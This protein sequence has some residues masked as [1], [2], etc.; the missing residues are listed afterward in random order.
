LRLA[1]LHI[2]LHRSDVMQVQQVNSDNRNP[3]PPRPLAQKR[4]AGS[5]EGR[6]LF[7]S[8]RCSLFSFSWLSPVPLQAGQGP[9]GLVKSRS[10]VPAGSP[11]EVPYPLQTGQSVILPP[12]STV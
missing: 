5:Q 8:S 6:G 4:C 1:S 11:S 2:N 3:Q 10:H 9:G 7:Q 12:L